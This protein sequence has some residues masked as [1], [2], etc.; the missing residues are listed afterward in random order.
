M[1]F[2]EHEFRLS[3][4]NDGGGTERDHLKSA[5]DQLAKFGMKPAAD[6]RLQAPP[7]PHQ[8][9]YLWSWFCEHSLGLPVNGSVPPAV[10]WE[11]LQA[12]SSFMRISVT[13]WEAKMLVRLGNLR[14]AIL[15]EKRKPDGNGN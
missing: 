10:T 3:R 5:S 8:V 15:M 12:W 1:A 4:T 11:S 7:L 6:T 13:P 2:A 9:R 14:C